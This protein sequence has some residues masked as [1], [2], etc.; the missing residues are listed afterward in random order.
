M[1][2]LLI[3][4]VLSLNIALAEGRFGVEDKSIF[5][6]EVK[7]EIA[8]GKT[9]N[10]GVITFEM[11]RPEFFNE[12]EK[13]ILQKKLLR[14]EV[15]A[16]KNNFNF[17]SKSNIPAGKVEAEF[18]KFL[19][20]ELSKFT[21]K[22]PLVAENGICNELQ[23]DKNLTCAPEP[24]GSAVN[25]KKV[26]GT[27]CEQDNECSSN[28][29]LDDGTGKKTKMCEDVYR[30]Y[31]PL[32][33]G[34]SCLSNPICGAGS[35]ATYNSQTSGIGECSA[36]SLSCA[37][38]QDCC[39]GSCV[40]NKC[41]ENKICKSCAPIGT[42]PKKLEACC[43][44]LYLNPNGV[45]TP[46]FPPSVIIQVKNNTLI[47]IEKTLDLFIGSAKAED[48]KEASKSYEQSLVKEIK[49][50]S[51]LK[52]NPYKD[53]G[54]AND[55][56]D[57]LVKNKYS[58]KKGTNFETCEVDF[59]YDYL[60]GLTKS[61]TID[62]EMALLAFSFANNFE[63]DQGKV[64]KD[65]WRTSGSAESTSINAR[66]I[67]ISKKLKDKRL[68][69]HAIFVEK[70][71]QMKCKCLD[72]SGYLNI[73][74][75]ANKEFF[76]KSCPEE[77]K[78]YANAQKSPDGKKYL[79]EELN[80]DASGIKGK[81]LIDDWLLKLR[82]TYRDLAVS[83]FDSSKDFKKLNDWVTNKKWD[84]T[85]Y[86]NTDLFKFHIQSSSVSMI[87]MGALA[88]AILAAGVIG[89]ISGFNP[90]AFFTVWVLLGIGGASI[91]GGV[92]VWTAASLKGAWSS[93]R[94]TIN[95][96]EVSPRSVSCGKKSTCQ[97]YTRTL[98]QPYNDICSSHISSNACVKKFM[99][100]VDENQKMR[101]IVDP[102]IPFDTNAEQM[103]YLYS[104]DLAKD[105]NAG[106]DRALKEMKRLD[107]K[108]YA[109]G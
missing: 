71:K 55:F 95:D 72:V 77:M 26:A 31:R 86:K 52:D 92:G 7:Q 8:E 23:C 106:Y 107:P 91:A 13:Y 29:C 28:E 63:V 17:L 105:L 74:D 68:E 42:K 20:I 67:E 101:Y 1:I 97:E 70:S 33:L 2:K 85:R 57:N 96:Y 66:A 4:L 11:I 40:N 46:D 100:F 43:E 48:V 51:K 62:L 47:L 21:T 22:L 76:E 102:I 90:A 53:H 50:D 82:D 6:K 58:F 56:G 98:Q 18:L 14:S 30:C 89:I 35:C 9:Q 81:T 3:G 60:N 64:I 109:G 94:P 5:L 54:E 44:G 27:K 10:G 84:E 80:G 12:L 69:Q 39:S 36:L 34:E 108:T 79:D 19:D 75:E 61:G 87:G 59:K 24:K 41:S 65:Y 99:I 103:G 73:K 88:G 38:N 93:L 15:S 83:T 25:G 16:I 32:N 104:G 78:K 49:S 37:K 45:C